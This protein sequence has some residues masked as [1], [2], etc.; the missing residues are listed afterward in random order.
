MTNQMGHNST[1]CYRLKVLRVDISIRFQIG[2]HNTLPKH[3]WCDSVV[4]F[5]LSDLQRFVYTPVFYTY[6]SEE[7]L[8]NSG[9]KRKTVYSS[10]SQTKGESVRR[11]RVLVWW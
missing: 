11:R 2:I 9:S 1:E 7:Q 3:M 4:R 5:F 6:P 10:N 8:I